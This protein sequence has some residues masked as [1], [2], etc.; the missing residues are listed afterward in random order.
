ML[1]KLVHDANHPYGLS[2]VY[3]FHEPDEILV[4]Y[5]IVGAFEV[6]YC[7]EDMR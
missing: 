3:S 4:L 7:L 5:G 2:K 1:K 6:L